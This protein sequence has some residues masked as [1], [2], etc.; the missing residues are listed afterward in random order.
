VT[1][2]WHWLPTKGDT[3]SHYLRGILSSDQGLVSHRR[4]IRPQSRF[5]RNTLLPQ[6]KGP[7]RDSFSP[8]PCSFSSTLVDYY[9]WGVVVC[10]VVEGE[11]GV[12]GEVV[13]DGLV[14]VSEP[15]LAVPVLLE[16]VPVPLVL[17][18]EP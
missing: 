6:R 16:P 4:L 8:G 12:D 11:V 3:Q 10:G 14:V 5:F 9:C 1:R 2:K 7:E 18:P 13:E 17:D 15:G